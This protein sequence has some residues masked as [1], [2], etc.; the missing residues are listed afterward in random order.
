MSLGQWSS[1]RRQDLLELLDQLNPRI[2]ELTK[3]IE[4]EAENHPEATATDEPSGSECTDRAFVLII[5]NAE[6]FHCGK[7]I[8][9]YVGLAGRRF[10]RGT[11]APWAHQQA[12]QLAA[13]QTRVR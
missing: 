5:G 8:A 13:A 2:A 3:A 10:Q 4:H 11:T 12:R 6:R 9:G 7:Q 1:R